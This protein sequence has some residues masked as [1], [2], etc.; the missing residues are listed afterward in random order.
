MSSPVSCADIGCPSEVETVIP[1]LP[2]PAPLTLGGSR[3]NHQGVRRAEKGRP[4]SERQPSGWLGAGP[5]SLIAW[6]Q[7]LVPYF[8]EV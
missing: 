1:L 2:H 4:A 5:W 6:V 7:I 3:T 8:L